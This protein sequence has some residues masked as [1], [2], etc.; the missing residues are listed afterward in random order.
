[1]SVTVNRGVVP[2]DDHGKMLADRLFQLVGADFL[3]VLNE[4]LV[5]G[6]LNFGRDKGR[7]KIICDRPLTRLIFEGPGTIDLCF[8]E[9]IEE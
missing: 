4:L 7:A 6:L 5:A 9:P 1:V 2:E 3:A 8:P